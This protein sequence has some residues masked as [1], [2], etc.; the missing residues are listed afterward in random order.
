VDAV[1]QYALE[2]ATRV[3][4]PYSAGGATCSADFV[5]QAKRSLVPVEGGPKSAVESTSIGH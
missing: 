3:R 1:N 2:A 4:A 5:C